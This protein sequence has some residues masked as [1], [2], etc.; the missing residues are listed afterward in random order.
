[1]MLVMTIAFCDAQTYQY[2]ALHSP[3]YGYEWSSIRKGAPRGVDL[4]FNVSC[5]QNTR[6]PKSGK[7]VYQCVFLLCFYNKIT[8]FTLTRERDSAN[9][10]I[11]I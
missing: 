3:A 9:S 11:V 5:D 2:L 8:S 7:C 10:N 1:M 4:H 6:E